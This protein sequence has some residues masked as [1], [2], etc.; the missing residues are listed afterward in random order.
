MIRALLALVL[1]AA[2]L[3]AQCVVHPPGV[4][5][6]PSTSNCS[7]WSGHAALGFTLTASAKLGTQPA[8]KICE[9]G[10]THCGRPFLIALAGSVSP[11]PFHTNIGCSPNF[12][13]WYVPLTTYWTG[14]VP[15]CHPTHWFHLFPA[16]PNDI[17]L[18]WT[19]LYSQVSIWD[20][21]NVCNLV[22]SRAISIQIVP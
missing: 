14:N 13:E 10:G 18:L 21:N 8:Y 7:Q 20:Q 19:Y 22:T 12:C 4:S 11:F 16:I 6:T 5:Y 9:S 3:S 2:S 15:Y 17:N 1:A